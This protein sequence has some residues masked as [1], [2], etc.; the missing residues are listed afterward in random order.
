MVNTDNIVLEANATDVDVIQI[1]ASKA[2]AWGA[3]VDYTTDDL[4]SDESTHL[5][6]QSISNADLVFITVGMGGAPAPA[7]LLMWRTW[8]KR[9]ALW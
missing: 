9:R 8:P 7:P 1:G 4:S 5:L 6:R 3:G 2:R